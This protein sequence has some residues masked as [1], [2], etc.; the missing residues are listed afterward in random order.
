M[1][2]NR[3]SYLSEPV[4]FVSG[5]K[6]KYETDKN[7]DENIFTFTECADKK[8]YQLKGT[9]I[10]LKIM[11]KIGYKE[12]G[13]GINGQGIVKPIEVIMRPKFLGLGYKNYNKTANVIAL[14]ETSDEN[15]A[16]SQLSE[17]RKTEFTVKESRLAELDMQIRECLN[18]DSHLGNL[19]LELVGDLFTYMKKRFPDEYKLCG[20]STIA[21]SFALPLFSSLFKGWDPLIK[22]TDHIDVISVW[23]DLLQGDDINSPYAHLFIEVVFCAVNRSSTNTWQT[24]S[25]EPLLHFLDIW[26]RLT[27]H[28]ALQKILATK[29]ICSSRRMFVSY[30]KVNEPKSMFM[31]NGTVSKIEGKGKVILK[32]T[33]GKD[34]VLSN[35]L[36]VPNI[37]KHLISRPILSNKG[38]KLMFESN[39]FI[40]TKGDVYAGKESVTPRDLWRVCGTYGTVVDV[41]IPV[42][43]SKAG[44]R[45]A[46]VRFIKVINLDRLVKNLCTLWIGNYHLYT[47]QVRFERPRINQFPPLNGSSMVFENQGLRQPHGSYAKVVN[48]TSP[49]VNASPLLSSA[50]ALV[51][52]NACIVERD[53]SKHIMGRVKD[54][55]S[56]SN[57]LPLLSAEGFTDV[58]LVYIG[59][60][61]VMFEFEKVESKMNM[62]AHPGVASWFHVIQEASNEFVSDERIVWVDIEGVPLHAWVSKR[63]CL[64]TKNPVSIIETFKI[65]VKGKVFM[66]RAKELFTWNPTF[67]P[68]KAIVYSSDDDSVQADNEN[69]VHLG[70]NDVEGGNDNASTDDGVAE[71]VFDTGS[72][73]PKANEHVNEEGDGCLGGSYSCGS[74]NRVFYGRM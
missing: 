61:W 19:I 15:K 48:A 56:I 42:K 71:T 67:L 69:D 59:G 21:C 31:G 72:V 5:C 64:A 32:L 57:L 6:G 18:N 55:N 70:D 3:R 8:V 68:P 37:T 46:F 30:R 14:Q 58:K 54:F 28:A 23:K 2:E 74:S 40:I 27:P 16:L 41:F 51:L 29:H 53:L 24:T 13:L 39:K 44:K 49:M 60:M 1:N 20:L 62:M 17:K 12:G 65:I 66:V 25:P 11:R 33:S 73:D 35:V 10:R 4:K 43:R 47:N 63:L 7:S 34:L 52:D 26:E 50:P 36:H 38:F 45:F 22:P 9:G